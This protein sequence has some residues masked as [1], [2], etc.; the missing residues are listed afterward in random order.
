[1]IELILLI[2][3]ESQLTSNISSML[4]YTA[5]PSKSQGLFVTDWFLV[6]YKG[7]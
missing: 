3:V 2:S 4:I 5:P 1:M 7:K 6:T